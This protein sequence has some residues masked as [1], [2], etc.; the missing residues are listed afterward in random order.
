M[1]PQGHVFVVTGGGSGIGRELVLQLLASGAAVAAVDINPDSL[2]E[3]AELAGGDSA[4]VSTHVV[5]I[6]DKAAV[7]ALPDAVLSAH[8]RV[9]GLINNAGIIQPFVRVAELDDEA[10]ARVMN[11]NFYGTLYMVRAFLPH[12]L[13]RPQAHI[14][15]VSSMGGFLPVPGQTIYGAAKAAVKLFTEGLRS[16][17]MDSAVNVTIVFPGAIATNIVDNSG[18][19]QAAM[20]AESDADS[21]SFTALS[22]DEAARQIIAGMEKNAYR[23]LVGRD[24]RMMD[25]LYRL[26]PKY[27]AELIYKQMKSLL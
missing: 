21:S 17:L 10:I 7:A 16:E 1:K 26:H 14:V 22:A 8:G 20:S 4:K 27:A 3:T 25:L 2:A 23:V 24:A 11:V 9:D 6:A 13:Q 15:N 12:L 18:L 19:D 5:D